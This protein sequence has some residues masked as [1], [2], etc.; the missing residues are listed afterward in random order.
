MIEISGSNEDSAFPAKAILFGEYTVMLG[1]KALAVPLFEF[2]GRFEFLKNGSLAE[3]RSAQLSLPDLARSQAARAAGLDVETFEKELSEGLF[4]R[5]N[6]PN[7][8]GIGSS[9]AVTAAV[10][11]RFSNEKALL[12]L[13]SLKDRLAALE[14][15]FHGKSSGLDPLVS[16]SKRAVLSQN[17]DLEAFGCPDLRADGA[18]FFLLDTVKRRSARPIIE[19][20]VERS[21]SDEAF[22]KSLKKE[23][24]PFNQ[25]AI[26]AV[27]AQKTSAL[28]EHFS[29]IAAFQ[30]RHFEPM[31]PGE[32]GFWAAEAL[33]TDYQ[34]L[35]ICGA[36]GGG[37]MLGLSADVAKTEA[38]FAAQRIIWL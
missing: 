27:L 4:F 33:K 32:Q 22:K 6:I 37:F 24:L 16:F 11:H 30:L 35:K 25:A 13:A 20:F 15:F 38:S 3:R 34:R 7:G 5:S 21:R 18:R 1:G 9:G 28:W 26:D 31:L 8:Y 12:D 2:S 17:D 23:L 10:F 19:R 29:K 36:G 14:A